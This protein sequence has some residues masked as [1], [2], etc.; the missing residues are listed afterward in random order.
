M[1]IVEDITSGCIY[2]CDDIVAAF[3]DDRLREVNL[4]EVRKREHNQ[5]L[6]HVLGIQTKDVPIFSVAFEHRYDK[7]HVLTDDGEFGA[8]SPAEFDLPNITIEELSLIW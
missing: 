2:R 6:G 4:S 5:L 7:P 8:L 3:D 1:V